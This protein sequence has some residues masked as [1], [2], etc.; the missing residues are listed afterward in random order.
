MVNDPVAQPL[1]Q[2]SRHWGSLPR[3]KTDLWAMIGQDG[4]QSIEMGAQ[5]LFVFSDTLLA[6]IRRAPERGAQSLPFHIDLDAPALFLA[7]CA[8][9][10]SG[11]HLRQS[12]ARLAYLCDEDGYPKEILVATP[13]ER[14][15][16]IRFW[17][18][19]GTFIDGRIYLYYLGIQT[20]NP[21]SIWGFENLGVGLAVLDPQTGESHRILQDGDW[22]L[23]KIAADDF[24]FG[25][26][27]VRHKE[28]LFVFGSVRKDYQAHGILCRV[29][30]SSISDPSAYTYQDDSGNWESSLA[31]A[32]SIGPTGPE[33]SV[34]YN[35]YLKKFLLVY[36]DPYHKD[37][38]V[39]FADQLDG[40][41]SAPKK[42]G[43]LPHHPKSELIYMGFEHPRF[44]A[45]DGKRVYITYCQP[46]F[47]S[48]DIVELC[49][50]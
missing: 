42:I 29:P 9:I 44:S 40:P 32:G 13:E 37:L 49:F 34:S 16:N 43:R 25:V 10:T 30:V 15:A 1:L 48:N 20:V 31:L 12:L 36:V 2:Y 46:Y 35:R 5:T 8:G 33:Y 17:P 7:N 23:W 4:G 18:E 47:S 27:V 22:R 39:R 26:Q 21:D 3:I 19:H 38:Y 6:P 45:E 14:A 24:H 41:Y 11:Q 28:H 50:Q